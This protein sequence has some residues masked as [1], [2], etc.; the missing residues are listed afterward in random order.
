M[1]PM[2]LFRHILMHGWSFLYS[3]WGGRPTNFVFCHTNCMACH[4]NFQWIFEFSDFKM[5]A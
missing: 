1:T 4:T 5:F 2:T 3:W